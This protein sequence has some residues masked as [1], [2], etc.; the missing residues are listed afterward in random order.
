MQI[1]PF[2]GVIA[3]ILL[4]SISC[5]RQRYPYL[6]NADTS[7]MNNPNSLTDAFRD[8]VTPFNFAEACSLIPDVGNPVLLIPHFL[9]NLW[10]GVIGKDRV[11]VKVIYVEEKISNFTITSVDN[12]SIMRFNG[13]TKIIFLIQFRDKTFYFGAWSGFRM[14]QAKAESEPIAQIYSDDLV[15]VQKI[16]KVKTVNKKAVI[17]CG[18]I[19]EIIRI[20]VNEVNRRNTP[21]NDG[22]VRTDADQFPY[23][24]RKRLT[25]FQR[26]RGAS[27]YTENDRTTNYSADY[28]YGS[29]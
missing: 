18:K 12:K 8:F 20:Y 10:Q 23:T 24:N 16:L 22:G 11:F 26:G 3:L 19:D 17:N 27:Q 9:N 4:G 7:M 25:S 2:S 1:R 15:K 28:A 29:E 13:F 21:R 6:N 14:I 5:Q